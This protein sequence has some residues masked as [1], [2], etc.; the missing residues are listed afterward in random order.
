MLS[1]LPEH[2]LR[3]LNDKLKDDVALWPA[4]IAMATIL[5]R[6]HEHIVPGCFLCC[7]N[8]DTKCVAYLSGYYVTAFFYTAQKH[9]LSIM[10]CYFI[11][12]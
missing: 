3:Y 7:L 4:G 8:T 1:D 11:F 6:I 12:L 2:L 5:T 9:D 10:C